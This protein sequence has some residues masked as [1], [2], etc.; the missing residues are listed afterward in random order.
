[1]RRPR[2]H[3]RAFAVSTQLS[4][5]CTVNVT[6]VVFVVVPFLP[7]IVIV[8]VPVV[9]RRFTVTVIVDDPLPPD[10]ELGLNES[11]TRL[12]WP[13]PDNETV[14]VNP[15]DGVTVMVECPELPRLI[16]SDVG[17]ALSE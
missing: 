10:T 1:M 14:P 15:P 3:V 9:A 16:V 4:F 7:E 13:E 12:P 6:V 11:V 5:H 2:Q 17:D 8:R